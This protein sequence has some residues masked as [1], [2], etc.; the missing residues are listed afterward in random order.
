MGTKVR[1]TKLGRDKD[2]KK[3]LFR[4]LISALILNDRIK[5]THS[6]ATAIKGLVDKLVN[7][8]KDGGLRRRDVIANFLTSSSATQKLYQDIV[9]RFRNRQSGYTRILDTGKRKGDN[10][11]MVVMEWM[12][13]PVPASSSDG[14]RDNKKAGSKKL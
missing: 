5:T 2:H 14:D 11:R 4:N 6:K 3:A 13:K 9:V 12:R 7:Q 8:A 10:A 1:R